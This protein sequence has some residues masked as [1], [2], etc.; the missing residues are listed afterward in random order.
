MPEAVREAFTQ[1]LSVAK[2][3]AYPESMWWAL[4]RAHILSQPWPW[5]HTVAH[6]RML[7]LA[8]RQ[9]DRHEAIGQVVRVA[10]AA[11]G[12]ATGRYP[13]GNT[14][15][16]TVGLRETMLIPDDLAQLLASEAP[17]VKANR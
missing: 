5:P 11:P 6:W 8:L 15:R 1:E 4:E 17:G 2:E 12:S 3:A 13:R 16:A 7:S 9:H 14:G 10:V